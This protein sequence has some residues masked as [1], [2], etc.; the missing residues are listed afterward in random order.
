MKK[1]SGPGNRLVEFNCQ[2]SGRTGETRYPNVYLAYYCQ[3]QDFYYLVAHYR[4]SNQ[5][6]LSDTNYIIQSITRYAKAM[7]KVY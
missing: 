2:W 3:S 1:D 6:F 4:F 5:G 7:Q